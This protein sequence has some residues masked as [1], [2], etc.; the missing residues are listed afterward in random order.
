MNII[1]KVTSLCNACCVYCSANA[2]SEGDDKAMMSREVVGMVLDLAGR[3]AK[4]E[5]GRQKISVILHGG[6]PLIKDGHFLKLFIEERDRRGGMPGVGFGIQ[7][8]LTLLNAGIIPLLKE[9]ITDKVSTSYDPIG[10]LRRL[11]SKNDY[12]D[13]FLRNIKLLVENGF[14]RYG[15]IYVVTRLSLGNEGEIYA[16]LKSLPGRPTI[17]LNAIY[18]SGRAELDASRQLCLEKG[19]YPSFIK[20]IYSLWVENGGDLEFDGFGTNGMWKGCYS[21][22]HCPLFQIGIGPDGSVYNCGRMSDSDA[23]RFGHL[24]KNSL[25][26]IIENPN[27]IRLLNRTVLLKG[28]ECAG[29][30]YWDYCKGGCPN[31]SFI[32]NGDAFTRSPRCD[33]VKELMRWNE[34]L[35]LNI[36]TIG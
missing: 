3:I 32:T 25:D 27:R 22:G 9:L 6:E 12:N 19:D 14:E 36:S 35:G 30:R 20:R 31:E 4:A 26:D 23:L 7:T 16:R 21:S 18:R 29:C 28:G 10:T 5:K 2:E 1:C 11:I 33:D 17:K 13:L 8:N 34:G 24:S 15:L